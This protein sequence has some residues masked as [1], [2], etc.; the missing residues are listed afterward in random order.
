MTRRFL[1]IRL[2]LKQIMQTPAAVAAVR[3]RRHQD[4]SAVRHNGAAR[5]RVTQSRAT[6]DIAQTCYMYEYVTRVH[7]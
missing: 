5:S 6:R 2:H 7:T 4:L 1:L 3:L